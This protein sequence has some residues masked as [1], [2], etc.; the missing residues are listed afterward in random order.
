MPKK[1]VI[2]SSVFLFSPHA[3]HAFDGENIIIPG[4]TMREIKQIAADGG[5]S[6]RAAVAFGRELDSIL[7]SPGNTVELENGGT[8]LFYMDEEKSIYQIAAEHNATIITRDPL[9]RVTARTRGIPAEAFHDE[10][11]SPIDLDYGGRVILY[12]SSEEIDTFSAE[13]KLIL[14]P[15]RGYYAMDLDG[16][17]KSS[18]YKLSPNEY[19]CMLAADDPLKSMLG[20]FDGN[21]IVPL[22]KASNIY[23]VFPL[24]M[25]QRFAMRWRRSC[26]SFVGCWTTSKP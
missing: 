15:D 4:C 21:G 20:R 10:S 17:T 22:I 14:D 12:V 2:D 26:L 25:G 8:L 24:N 1:Y 9:V 16:K 23:G 18:N 3:L 13:R 7:D 19:V 6:R 5:E 11:D